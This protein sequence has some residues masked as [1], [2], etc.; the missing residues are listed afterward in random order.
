MIFEKFIVLGNIDI[1]ILEYI[2]KFIKLTNKNR[3]EMKTTVKM[4]I[5]SDSFK[6]SLNTIQVA[7]EIKKGAV[8]V[9]PEAEFLSVPVADGGEGTVETM[10]T[11]LG[12]HYEY[13]QVTGPNGN[14]VIAKY[15]VLEDG[16]AVIEMASASGLTLVPENEKDVM[17]ATTYGTGELIK[18]AMDYGCSEIYIGIGGSATN[19]GGVGMAQALGT[20]FYDK[21]GREVGFGAEALLQICSI[22][23][24]GLDKRIKNTKIMVMSDVT[25]PL[26]GENGAAAIYGPQKGA[27]P[28]QIKILDKA[29]ENLAEKMHEYVG[30]EGRK[31]GGAG[32]AGGLGMGLAGFLGAEIESGI[33]VILRISEFS[34]KL[35]WADLVITGE[36]KVDGQTACGKAIS[37]IARHAEKKQVP[38]LVV[39]GSVGHGVQT[40][41]EY[42]IGGIEASVC[43]PM[44]LEEAMEGSRFL[45]ADA[46][47]RMLRA[48][49]VG[50][51]IV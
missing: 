41:F 25:N 14:K 31:M 5:A 16:K 13:A 51:Q 40:I 15:G 26:L 43:R 39:C 9:F 50:I 36:G 20:H 17:K 18:A 21:D 4:L 6:G 47:E 28:E 46:V 19:D 2:I 29:L 48:V 7:E 22:D 35:D 10:I 11:C 38:V 8:R 34:K 1:K 27:T 24:S 30:F 33:E 44:S 23:I 37:G 3:G 32:A 12:G 45:V 49:K 42:G